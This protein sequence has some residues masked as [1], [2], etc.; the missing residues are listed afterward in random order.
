MVKEMEYYDVL[1][2]SPTATESEIKKAY[3]IKVNSTTVVLSLSLLPSR[4]VVVS[5][6]IEHLIPVS[7]FGLRSRRRTWI[8]VD[9]CCWCN[10][11]CGGYRNLF[12]VDG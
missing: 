11:L 2:I 1:G 7:D 9:L 10:A 3:Y 6:A 12:S 4:M 8:E 5:E